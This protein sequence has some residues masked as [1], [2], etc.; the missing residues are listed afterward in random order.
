MNTTEADRQYDIRC[1]KDRKTEVRC[2]ARHLAELKEKC[3][4]FQDVEDAQ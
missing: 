4:L 2:P 1:D 3:P